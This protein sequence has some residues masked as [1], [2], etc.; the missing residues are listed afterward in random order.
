MDGG[1]GVAG[2]VRKE[3]D[4]REWQPGRRERKRRCLGLA[5]RVSFGDQGG[6]ACPAVPLAAAG[7]MTMGKSQKKK[8]T[9]KN[10]QLKAEQSC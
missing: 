3:G 7:L 2:G 6:H 5:A 8:I 9:V 10:W 1:G 4:W